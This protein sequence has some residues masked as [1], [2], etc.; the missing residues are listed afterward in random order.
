MSDVT[1]LGH[2][3]SASTYQ[4]LRLGLFWLGRFWLS[5]KLLVKVEAVLRSSR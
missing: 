4:H 1:T 2:A 3:E 5:G